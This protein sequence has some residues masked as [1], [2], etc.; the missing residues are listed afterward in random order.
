MNKYSKI[1][2]QYKQSGPAQAMLHALKLNKKDL[3]KPQIGIGSV[4]FESNP[5]NVKL[6]DLTQEI[7]YSFKNFNMLPFRFSSVGVSDG[8]SM[9]TNGMRYSLPSRDLIADIKPFGRS[10]KKVALINL[11]VK[12]SYKNLI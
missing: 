3:T 10:E 8:I 9:G 1:I 12:L 11:E 6:N 4:W 7:K 2:T 5:C